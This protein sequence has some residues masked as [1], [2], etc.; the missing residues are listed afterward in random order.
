VLVS[1]VSV[2]AP[3]PGP[4][5]TEDGPLHTPAGPDV[6]E[7]T[8][9]TY[10]PLKVACELA[11]ADRYGEGLLVIR[12]TYVVGP[13]DYT[14]RFPY[15]VQRIAAGGRVLCPDDPAAPMQVID[16]RDQAT[17]MVDLLE[18]GAGGTFHTVSPAPPSGFGDLLDAVAAQVAPPGTS[19]HWVDTA[20]LLAA[21]LDDD[22]LPLWDP[23]GVDWWAGACD[24]N[25]AYAAG[26]SPR[27]LADT[28]AD[29]LTWV[30]TSRRPDRIGVP[31]GTERELVGG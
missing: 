23:S 2:Y 13:S 3:P 7:V 14:W 28:V 18:R 12:P 22:A 20:T 30:G 10:G 24:P 8:D 16:A 6:V 5:T 19:L 9:D 26:L 4:G 21:G 15:W 17:F 31:P 27:P 1:T 29:T 25:R 11:A